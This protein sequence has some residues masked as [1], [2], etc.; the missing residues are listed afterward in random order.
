MK[1]SIIALGAAFTLLLGLPAAV[2]H[3]ASRETH[4]LQTKR[5]S[6]TLDRVEV[7]LGVDGNLKVP[8]P[9][10]GRVPRRPPMKATA[11]VTYEEKTLDSPAK[12]GESIRS[13]RYYEKA[14]ATIQIGEDQFRPT[15]REERRLI[16][17]QIEGAQA[18]LFSPSGTLSREE[19]DLIDL[20]AN[21]L[22]LD[23]LLPERPVALN[24]TWKHPDWLVA[25]LC[26][27]DAIG[28]NDA[29]SV[30][31]LVSDGAARIEMSGSVEGIADGLPTSI[32]LKAKYR[33]DMKTGRITRFALDLKENRAAGPVG[34]GLDVA[35]RVQIEVSTL[36]KPVH[37]TEAALQDLKLTPTP[38]LTRLDHKS[39]QGGW[40]LA[41]DR[42][43]LVIHEKQ[44]AILLRM[45]D[46]GDYVAQC[47]VSLGSE[48]STGSE[49]TLAKFQEDIRQALGK[50]FGRFVRAEESQSEGGMRVYRVVV[51]GEAQR[52]PIQWIY[53]RLADRRARQMIFAFTVKQELLGRFAEA[54]AELVRGLRFADPKAASKPT[55][56]ADGKL[57]EKPR[58]V[59][60]GEGSENRGGP[61]AQSKD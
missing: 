40:E 45:V 47:N 22:L 24:D 23:G 48:V 8:D 9:A 38:E 15:L 32:E 37:L 20:I 2:G 59:A 31:Q 19:S 44:D 51:Q 56:G 17:N 55:P 61:E 53:Y 1:P 58:P 39:A 29:K 41:H 21:S 60:E 30:L 27:L 52:I 6:G 35:A 46:A 42:R 5:T 28:S 36:D 3:A 10:G 18:T 4:N 43:W 26:G 11:T 54:D 57:P 33:F 25:A 7:V 49:L 34:P 12:A 14:E 13:I 50:S 16:A